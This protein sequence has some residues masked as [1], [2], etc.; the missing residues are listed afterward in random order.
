MLP[1]KSQKDITECHKKRPLHSRFS[2]NVSFPSRLYINWN[3]LQSN[4]S[5]QVNCDVSAHIVLNSKK[6]HIVPPILFLILKDEPPETSFCANQEIS[7]NCK[8]GSCSWE[9]IN[10]DKIIAYILN[11]EIRQ[12]FL[13]KANTPKRGAVKTE[14]GTQ[15]GLIWRVH[16]LI[17]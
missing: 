7:L 6:I 3:S 12:M 15:K 1:A 2:S 17:H 14:L 10:L 16:Q 11:W 8:F 4:I 9:S 13:R 5:W